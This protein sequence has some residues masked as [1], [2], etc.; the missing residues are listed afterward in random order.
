MAGFLV[1]SGGGEFQ[2]GLEQAD[3]FAL[4]QAGG[5]EAKVLIVTAGAN[6]T[7]SANSGLSWF[8][9]LGAT[10]VETLA[11]PDHTGA[12]REAAPAQLAG[13]TLIYLAGAD[14]I[15]LYE[16]LQDSRAWAAIRQAFAGGATLVGANAG[17]MVLMEHLYDPGSGKVRAGLGMFPNTIFVPQFNGPGRK[18][19]AQVQKS[20]PQ[21]L[22]VGIDEKVA[23]GGRGND[24]QVLGRGWVTIYRQGK[25]YKYQGGQPFKM[26][27]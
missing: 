6:G 9:G 25:P 13:A 20:V 7:A 8:R 5:K 24:W 22:L 21:A 1:L 17:A 2:K 18:W 19:A 10:T 4:Q 11:L 26:N 16:T 3:Q 14:P 12:D 27:P 15:P 23:I